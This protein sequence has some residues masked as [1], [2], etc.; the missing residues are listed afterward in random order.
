MKVKFSKAESFVNRLILHSLDNPENIG[1]LYGQTGIIIV[2]ANY[3]RQK[4]R[5]RIEEIADTLYDN[6]IKNAHTMH[7]IGFASGLSGICWGIEYLVQHGILEGPAHDICENV[8]IAIVEKLQLKKNSDL[9]LETG[10]L[11]LWHYTWARI[12]GN[13]LAGL[14]LPF[15]EEYLDEWHKI[16]VDNTEAFPREA[17]KRLIGAMQGELYHDE[18]SVRP[19]INNLNKLL[20]NDISLRNGIAGYISL[21]Y[22]TND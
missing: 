14:N 18:L 7:N 21:K 6:V 11:G 9:S 20:I 8:D 12:Q 2:L 3:A 22:L 5:F 19:F 1:L 10:L 17:D 15:P 4:N 13:M 16:L